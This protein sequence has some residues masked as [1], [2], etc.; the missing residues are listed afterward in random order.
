MDVGCAINAFLPS[1]QNLGKF[2]KGNRATKKEMFKT[3]GKE[4]FDEKKMKGW[5]QS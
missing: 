2:V 4:Q 5:L 1:A 3:A